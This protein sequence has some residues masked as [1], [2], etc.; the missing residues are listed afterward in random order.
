MRKETV[1]DVSM[2]REKKK[3]I[4]SKLNGIKLL[5]LALIIV[6]GSVSI[7]GLG[8]LY[9]QMKVMESKTLTNT[10]YIWEM[11]RN[12]ESE[13]GYILAGLIEG[14]LET[15]KE[16]LLLSE[17]DAKR[18]EEVLAL[19]KENHQIDGELVQ[20]VED[21]FEELNNYQ[22]KMK[23]LILLNTD[24]GDTEAFELCMGEYLTTYGK[25][26]ERLPV[27]G[28]LQKEAA[29]QQIERSLFIFIFLVVFVGASVVAAMVLFGRRIAE[30]VKNILL[31][32]EQM[33][34]ASTALS[35]GD[36]SM[37][38]TYTSEDEFGRVKSDR[39]HVVL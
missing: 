18:T 36:F 6:L 8:I 9:S 20:E 16:Y 7:A 17:E 34:K 5:G 35:E 28:E 15:S 27:I 32:L 29:R 13:V 12:I 1:P 2:K 10:E 3:G 19:Y 4:V 39:S 24:E 23:D 30:L 21:L 31:P 22:T 25:L 33:E 26:T 11:R 14:D 38:I 37:E